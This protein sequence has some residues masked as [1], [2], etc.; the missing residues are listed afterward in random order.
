M[1]IKLHATRALERAF[2]ACYL[3]L[4]A[5]PWLLPLQSWVQ[6]V[7]C[8][9]VITAA[10]P[11]F[12]ARS[13]VRALRVGP[14]GGLSLVTGRDRQVLEVH[15]FRVPRLL[16]CCAEIELELRDG[17]KMTLFIPPG[18]CGADAFRHLRKY[19]LREKGG[20]AGVRRNSVGAMLN[21][22]SAVRRSLGAMISETTF[23]G[24]TDHESKNQPRRP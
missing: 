2:T 5:L 13:P 4:G 20:V 3:A 9:A 8:L 22:L 11:H 10:S 23:T 24:D 21:C 6:A 16:R 15:A 1:E 18:A 17:R 19:L 7:A 14:G 12:S